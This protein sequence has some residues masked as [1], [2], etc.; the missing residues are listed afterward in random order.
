MR[1]GCI[2]NLNT[3]QLNFYDY[4]QLSEMATKKRKTSRPYGIY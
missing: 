2:F 1:F 4:L 3:H